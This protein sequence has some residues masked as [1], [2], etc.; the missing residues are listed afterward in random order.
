MLRTEWPFAP[1]CL[2]SVLVLAASPGNLVM[3]CR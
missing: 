1:L 3:K 2:L